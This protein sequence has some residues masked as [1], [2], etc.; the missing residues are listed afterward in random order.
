MENLEFST[1]SSESTPNE[2][3]LSIGFDKLPKLLPGS[4]HPQLSEP[5][6][7]TAIKLFKGLRFDQSV[8]FVG[9]AHNGPM[10]STVELL[11][12]VEKMV[13]IICGN[14]NNN[15]LA[16]GIREITLY[17]S[18]NVVIKGTKSMIDLIKSKLGE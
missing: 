3:E 2:C 4:D 10:S 16:R 11:E 1:R 7:S 5:N 18:S 17:Y 6:L 15:M 13:N 8:I 9:R 14:P 12:M